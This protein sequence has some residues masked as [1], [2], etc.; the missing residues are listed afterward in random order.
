MNIKETFIELTRKTYP[1]GHEDEL[2]SFLPY[3][4]KTDEDGNYYY[5]VGKGSKSIFACHL[6]TASK[7]YE[8]VKHVFDGKFIRTNKKTILGA[9][10]KAGVTILLYMIH[11]SVPGLYYFFVGEEVGCI[12]STAASK[13]E[14]FFS[15]YD[16]IISFDRRGTNSI[17]T[18]QSSK[19]TCSDSFAD[20]LSKEYSKFKLDL[21]KDDTGV[22]TDSAEFASSISEC[23]NISVGYYKEHTHDEHQDIEFLENL[24]KASVLVDWENLP[25]SRDKTKSEWKTYDYSNYNYYGG[26]ASWGNKSSRRATYY[27]GTTSHKKTRRG[28]RKSSWNYYDDDFSDFYGSKYKEV[29]KPKAFLNDL[30]HELNIDELV[31]N[32]DSTSKDYYKGVKKLFFNDSLTPEEYRI[33][34]EQCLNMFDD[35]DKE[36]AEAMEESLKE[37]YLL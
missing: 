2:T 29:S 8:P 35:S 36:F 28:G 25:V 3:G 34:K 11:H 21:S 33:I 1:Y 32:H 7:K 24:A 37:T 9:D 26:D 18:H 31:I 15:K 17:I 6:D 5:E 23:T 16:R 14:D 22:Y 30:D 27:G 12:G 13:R 4:Y 10:D 20:S 19:R